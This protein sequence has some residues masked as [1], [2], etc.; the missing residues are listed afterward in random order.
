MMFSRAIKKNVCRLPQPGDLLF[1]VLNIH[2]ED[3]TLW[4]R[5]NLT[6]LNRH[7]LLGFVLFFAKRMTWWG[8]LK[9]KKVPLGNNTPF[10]LIQNQFSELRTLLDITVA[11]NM[12]QTGQKFR[13][14]YSVC[15]FP[16][17]EREISCVS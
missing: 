7:L 8:N 6:S 16:A 3:S 13:L 9:L 15:D 5:R 4:H 12:S 10:C 17:A 11:K 14:F 2:K 1:S